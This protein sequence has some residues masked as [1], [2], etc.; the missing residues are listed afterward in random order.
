MMQ[1]IINAKIEAQC[2]MIAVCW[3]YFVLSQDISMRDSFFCFCKQS[4]I[5]VFSFFPMLYCHLLS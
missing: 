1:I 2:I 5:L 3:L 4:S